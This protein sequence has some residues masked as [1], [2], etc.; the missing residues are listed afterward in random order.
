MNRDAF[1]LG[2][3]ATS[4]QVLMLRELVAA[5]GGTEL[6]IGTA[7]F[8]W[9]V[10]VALGA[11]LGG[12]GTR[13]AN[14]SLLFLIGVFLLPLALA[15]TRLM[16]LLVTDT[17]GQMIPLTTAIP[18]SILAVAPTGLLSGWLFPAIARQGRVVGNA[19]TTVYLF[20]GLGAFAAG[21]AVT[22][23]VAVSLGGLGTSYCIGLGLMATLVV[24]A[25][26]WSVVPIAGGVVLLALL[27]LTQM[28]T[29]IDRICDQARYPGYSVEQSFDT[30][31]GHQ[32]ILSHDSTVVLVTDNTVEATSPDL[33]RSE[34]LIIPPLV[35]CPSARTAVFVGRSEFGVGQ[36]VSNFPNLRLTVVDPRRS[37]SRAL[38]QFLPNVNSADRNNDDPIAFFSKAPQNN[39][40]IVILSPGRFDSYRCG[41]LVTSSFM[42]LVKRSLKP[43][44]V[45]LLATAYDTD[46]YVSRETTQLL[47]AIAGTLKQSFTNVVV[48]PGNTTLV[49]ASDQADLRLPVDSIIARI[50][51]LL[52]RPQY[53]SGDYLN[54]RLSEL[55]IDR[56]NSAISAQSG[57]NSLN[58]PIL[59]T[60]EAWYRARA[61][62]PDRSLAGFFLGQPYWLIIL[63]VFLLL[64]LWWTTRGRGHGRTG[65]LLYVT[66]GL[67]SLSLE[68]LSF[69]LYQSAASSLYAHLAVL[70]GAFMLGLSLGT[71]LASRTIGLGI[72]WLSLAT[73][74]GATVMFAVTWQRV[75][76]R[77]ALVYHLLFLLVVA[78]ATGTLFVAATRYYYANSSG[79]NRGF[80]YAAELAGSAL[81][82]L[83]TT[84]V[85]L[86]L[87]G[88]N[89]LLVT[90]VVLLTL[91]LAVQTILSGGGRR[92]L[93]L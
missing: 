87:L 36:L 41:R 84:T 68:L 65:L 56:L 71:W 25:R 31:Y 89:W 29:Q 51:L 66:A 38:D 58:R 16:P 64:F 75:D 44:G 48:W 88:V 20:E 23:L 69:Y 91:V 3:L 42:G 83:L 39:F 30:P 70:I 47:G 77:L 67:G 72:G 60:Y 21:I 43:G 32:T 63:S 55:K 86:P 14:P 19:I 11:W 4:S 53:V 34:N 17:V 33:E 2:F 81:G 45:L 6:F 61:S 27:I 92:S 79:A 24:G 18:L 15:G 40:D 8:G 49:L 80:G 93:R 50:G 74:L 62:V 90:L 9:L 13:G 26:R 73:L 59:S 1:L 78:L 82:A 57:I 85:L 28:G 22:L 76:Y 46:R 54:D 7:L 12:R 5:F 37:L 52:Y 10:W 35:Y